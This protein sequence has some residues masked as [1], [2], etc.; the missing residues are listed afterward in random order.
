MYKVFRLPP[1]TDKMSLWT[2]YNP[3]S[4]QSRTQKYKLST[5]HFEVQELSQEL[6]LPG[7]QGTMPTRLLLRVACID[8]A[9]VYSSLLIIVIIHYISISFPDILRLIRLIFCF[10]DCRSCFLSRPCLAFTFAVPRWW[11]HKM[12]LSRRSAGPKLPW[13]AVHCR[14]K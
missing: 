6:L 3:H 5:L 2:T 9:D 8:N 10:S 14:W 12:G 4:T 13:S 11:K 7:A 1:A